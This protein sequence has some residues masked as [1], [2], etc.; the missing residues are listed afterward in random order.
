MMQAKRMVNRIFGRQTQG[1][2]LGTFLGVFTPSILTILGVILFLRT[3]WM[4]GNAGLLPAMAAVLGANAITL[5][6][7]VSVSS[8]AT[9]MFVEAGGAYYIISR[10]LGLQIGGAIGIPLFLA[11]TFSIT[12]YSFGFAESL[13]FIWP[14]API[15][16]LAMV[17]VLLVSL[18]SSHSAGLALRLQIPIMVLIGLFLR[19]FF[20]P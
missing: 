6:T 4:V 7:A 17:T 5:I 12:L 10:S 1:E 20:Q 15:Q 14:G 16:L 9:N 19:F 3:G 8:I 13:R 18:L 11:Q 2:K